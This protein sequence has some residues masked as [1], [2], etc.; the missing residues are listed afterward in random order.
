MI[1]LNI[2]FVELVGL[3]I[4]FFWDYLLVLINLAEKL[5]LLDFVNL[6]LIWGEISQLGCTAS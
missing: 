5:G 2:F 3:E 1:L 4:A 6:F